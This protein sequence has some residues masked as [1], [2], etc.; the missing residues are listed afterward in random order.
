[1]E[2]STRSFPTKS[3]PDQFYIDQLRW[4]YE[5]MVGDP[6]MFTFLATIWGKKNCSRIKTRGKKQEHHL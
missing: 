6:S 1:M 4:I 3:L 5:E 2:V